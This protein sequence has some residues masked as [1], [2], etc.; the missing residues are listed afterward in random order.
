MVAPASMPRTSCSERPFFL[1]TKS[2][3]PLTAYARPFVARTCARDPR[4]R[5]ATPRAM[6]G[7]T[8]AVI[9]REAIRSS[10]PEVV[11]GR[12]RH[13]GRTT[14]KGRLATCVRLH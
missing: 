14:R 3:D 12:W 9:E 6:E 8:S 4:Q 2:V 13:R 10:R 11:A 1:T 5:Q 7:S